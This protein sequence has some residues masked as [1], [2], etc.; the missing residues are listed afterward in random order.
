[1]S[2]LERNTKLKGLEIVPLI[3]IGVAQFL[4]ADISRQTWV[5]WVILS[6]MIRLTL[7]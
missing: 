3:V 7:S 6:G 1:M 2:S 5:V 4:M